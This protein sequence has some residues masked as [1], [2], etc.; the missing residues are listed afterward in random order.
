MWIG[1][2]LSTVGTWMQQVAQA[3]LIYRLSNSTFL[4]ALDPVIATIP[5]FLL[6][7][8]GGVV[9]DR[10]ERRSLLTG[11]QYV[12]M[13]CAL[14][15]TIMVATGH[16]H[17]WHILTC[18]FISGCGQAFGGPAY[19]ALIPTLVDKE[20]IPNAIAL[21]SMQF[22]SAVVLGP[23]ISAIILAKLGETL[24]FAVNTISFIAPIVALAMLRVR[25]APVKTSDSVLTSMKE[26]IHF[27]RSQGAMAGLIVLAFAHDV[28]VYPYADL[29]PGLRQGY[30]S[31]RR[32]TYAMFQSI[33]GAVPSWAR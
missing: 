32:G 3:W 33:T 8:I 12:Q 15:L 5:I 6:S 23:S 4:L 29:P 28:P 14:F 20:D 19:S 17:V 10:V 9:A 30:L 25:F 27:I 16:V 2:F 22:N 31:Q 18:S 21:N 24:C 13:I 7:L 11:S 1:A 26:G